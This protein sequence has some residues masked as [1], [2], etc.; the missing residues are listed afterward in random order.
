MRKERLVTIT[1]NATAIAALF[2]CFNQ[3]DLDGAAALVTEDFILTDL[4]AGVTLHGPAG[5]RQWLDGFLMTLPDARAE[6]TRIID[7]GEWVAS[8]HVGRGTNTGPIPSQ[9]GMLPPTGRSIE[10][11]IAE[12]YQLRDGKL[13]SLRA[14]YDMATM[15]RQLGLM[16]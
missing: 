12:V 10:L 8:E 4:A 16:G 13:A 1:A 14:Y 15:L 11:A 9:A 2:D 6:V 3:R 7:A 5:L